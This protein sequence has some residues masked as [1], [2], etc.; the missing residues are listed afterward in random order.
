MACLFI[1]CVSCGIETI[2]HSMTRCTQIR[3]ISHAEIELRSV[4]SPVHRSG[5]RIRLRQRF[6]LLWR[7]APMIHLDPIHVPVRQSPRDLEMPVP[8]SPTLPEHLEAARA[9]LPPRVRPFDVRRPRPAPAERVQDV[10]PSS[11][12]SSPTNTPAHT[13]R[14]MQSGWTSGWRMWSVA[15][16]FA[17]SS[18]VRPTVQ[19]AKPSSISSRPRAGS[20]S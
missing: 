19:R 11:L 16:T 9:Q 17:S 15:W 4:D 2:V 5:I 1:A 18:F 13:S 7:L 14:R 3:R 12:F 10:P 8:L 6:N 20:T